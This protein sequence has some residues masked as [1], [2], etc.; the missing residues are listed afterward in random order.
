MSALPH[1]CPPSDLT[2]QCTGLDVRDSCGRGRCLF[3]TRALPSRQLI[4]A[5]PVLVLDAA[6]YEA[7]GK[8]TA[9]SGY[10]FTWRDAQPP[11][12]ALCMGLGSLINH[13]TEPNVGW[14]CDIQARVIRFVTLRLISE[15]EELFINYGRSVWF[16]DAASGESSA[17]E[18]A[19][20]SAPGV[21]SDSSD[22]EETGRRRG[23][24]G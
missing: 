12:L 9:L 20:W 18:E 17:G 13:A 22:E 6:S 10:V 1:I 23:G 16:S 15:G 8:H 21:D 24:G 3:A 5:C 14:L 7:H 11:S 2:C 4:A 19:G